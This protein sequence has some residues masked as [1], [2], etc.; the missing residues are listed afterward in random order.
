MTVG[1]DDFKTNKIEDYYIFESNEQPSNYAKKYKV[2]TT[3]TINVRY[4]P[5]IGI[6]PKKEYK[7]ELKMS[8]NIIGNLK[9]D[10]NFSM[11]FTS[12][13]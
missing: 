9:K 3:S 8:E 11:L 10:V 4:S 13:A 12:R 2:Q 6:N 7:E 5:A 1:V